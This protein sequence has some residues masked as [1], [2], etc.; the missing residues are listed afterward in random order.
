MMYRTHSQRILDTVIRGNFDEVQT[1]LTH[2]WQGIPSHLH[3]LLYSN[4]HVNLVSACDCILFKAISSVLFPSI[5]Q[6]TIPENL[7]RLLKKFS[8]YFESWIKKSLIN[9][10]ENLISNKISMTHKFCNSLKRQLSVSR[11]SSA[12]RMIL[13]NPDLMMAMIH[14]WRS[15]DLEALIRETVGVTVS[16]PEADHQDSKPGN[17]YSSG[18]IIEVTVHVMRSAGEEFVKLMERDSS[19]ES[20][21]GWLDSLI[22]RCVVY[23][24]WD[25][26]LLYD[27]HN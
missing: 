16:A 7:V 3:S 19:L 14:D 12:A 15:L 4:V 27:S 18:N 26:A 6:P 20:F 5:I 17:F 25:I 1:L 23:V 8:Y 21:L 10:P 9:L 2:F 22:H 24:S 11:L 13:N